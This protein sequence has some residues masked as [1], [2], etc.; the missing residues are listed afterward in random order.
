MYDTASVCFGH[1]KFPQVRS[2]VLKCSTFMPRKIYSWC[3]STSYIRNIEVYAQPRSW[4]LTPFLLL[5]LKIENIG[6]VNVLRFP[7]LLRQKPSKLWSTVQLF[8]YSALCTSNFVPLPLPTS[9]PPPIVHRAT[10][11]CYQTRSQSGEMLTVPNQKKRVVFP[12]PCIQSWGKTLAGVAMRPFT[13]NIGRVV[14]LVPGINSDCGWSVNRKHPS[15]S[16][17]STTAQFH[18]SAEQ[19]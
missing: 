8:A 11:A 9:S 15:S 2:L 4:I 10:I 17:K 19:D 12:W 3:V 18:W 6:A 5:G 16:A 7:S 1:S 13:V 14:Q